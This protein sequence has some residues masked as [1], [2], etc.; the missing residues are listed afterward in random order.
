MSRRLWTIFLV[1]QVVGVSLASYSA[2]FEVGTGGVREFLWIPAMV[3]LLPGVFIGTVSSWPELP[4]FALVVII[5]AGWW[6]VVTL[7][8]QNKVRARKT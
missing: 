1:S 4:F 6:N 8:I 2:R 5:N 3:L 7:L